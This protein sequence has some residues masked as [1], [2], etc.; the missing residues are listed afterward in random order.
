MGNGAIGKKAVAI[1]KW[2]LPMATAFF[3]HGFFANGHGFFANGHGFFAN[4]HGFFCQ[5][6]PFLPMAT[7]QIKMK[8]LPGR[9]MQQ[10]LLSVS[11]LGW[12]EGGVGKS[13]WKPG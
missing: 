8:A 13:N 11:H 6:P 9:G 2:H 3:G 1:G 5:W 10:P 12:S 7:G 4:G